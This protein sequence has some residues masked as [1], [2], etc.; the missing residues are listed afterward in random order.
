MFVTSARAGIEVRFD[1]DFEKEERVII[2]LN[3]S[4]DIR[5]LKSLRAETTADIGHTMAKK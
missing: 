5:H 2:F 1:T 3:T 4:E